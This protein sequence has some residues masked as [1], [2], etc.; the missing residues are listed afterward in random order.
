MAS[1]RRVGRRGGTTR[2]PGR[3]SPM[4]SNT[5][6]PLH[7]RLHPCSG[8]MATVRAASRSGRSA[9]GHGG[10]CQHIAHLWSGLRMYLVLWAIRLW[11]WSCKD[12]TNRR[13]LWASPDGAHAG[14]IFRSRPVRHDSAAGPAAGTARGSSGLACRGRRPP[15]EAVT[16]GPAQPR[17]DRPEP[18]QPIPRR[19]VLRSASRPGRSRQLPCPGPADSRHVCS[20][21][22]A[23]LRVTP[24]GGGGSYRPHERTHEHGGPL[25][26]YRPRTWRPAEEMTVKRIRTHRPKTRREHPG[27]EALPPG[28][29]DPGIVRRAAPCWGDPR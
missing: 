17:P 11:G 24:H 7:S 2:P 15:G 20:D 28:P 21:P 13:S 12:G 3:I 25:P 8:W 27:H 22:H 29:R 5:I 18:P 6:T 1:R 19:R 23:H 16:P 9:G 4:S 10:R 14:G 26:C